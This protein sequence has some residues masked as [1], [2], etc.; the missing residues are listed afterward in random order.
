MTSVQIM[1]SDKS[2]PSRGAILPVTNTRRADTDKVALDTKQLDYTEKFENNATGQPVYHG[3]A[4][5]GT[6]VATAGW[7][8][9]KYTYDGTGAVTDIQY[10]DSANGNADNFSLKWSLRATYTYA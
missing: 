2:T 10:A 4:A 3:R 5:P 7:I 6:A 1:S 9:I 8:I